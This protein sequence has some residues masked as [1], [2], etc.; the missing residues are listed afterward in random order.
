[1]NLDGTQTTL[2]FEG[3]QG[4]TATWQGSTVA[5]LTGGGP[6]TIPLQFL[7]VVTGLGNNPWIDPTSVSLPSVMALVVADPAGL[8]L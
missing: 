7:V 1:M 8:G 6:I 2:T 5:N 4:T 3:V